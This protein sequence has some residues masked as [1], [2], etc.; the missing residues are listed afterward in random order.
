MT[1][2]EWRDRSEDG[3]TVFFRANHHSGEWRFMRRLKSEPDWT[4]LDNLPL[5]ELEVFR[6]VLWN[7][8]LRRRV[9]LKQVDQIDAMIFGQRELLVDEEE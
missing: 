6:E 5:E 2:H 9:P 1:R 7:K 4:Y 8:H 3:E